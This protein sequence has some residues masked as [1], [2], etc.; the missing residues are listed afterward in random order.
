MIQATMWMNLENRMFSER[1]QSQKPT[2]WMIPC[3]G[4]VQ[5]RSMH[6]DRTPTREYQGPGG[7]GSRDRVFLGGDKQCSELDKGG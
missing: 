3:L 4:D 7:E 5:N 2:R 1:S 6:R